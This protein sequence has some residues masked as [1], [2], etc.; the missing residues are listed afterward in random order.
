MQESLE[1][2]QTASLE[3]QYLHLSQEYSGSLLWFVQIWIGCGIE[4]PSLLFF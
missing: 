1:L 2:V 3:N 4:L